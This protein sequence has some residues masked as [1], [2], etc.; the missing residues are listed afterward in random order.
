MVP[1][2]S[3]LLQIILGFTR[4]IRNCPVQTSQWPVLWLIVSWVFWHWSVMPSVCAEIFKMLYWAQMKESFL[5]NKNNMEYWK[6]LWW[7]CLF[8]HMKKGPIISLSL[9]FFSFL[10]FLFCF[11]GWG[12]CNRK[13]QT[14]N[15][16]FPAYFQFFKQMKL[17]KTSGRRSSNSLSMPNS[18]INQFAEAY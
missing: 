16:T 17:K 13:T 1:P 15:L 2:G 12:V 10:F 4:E 14:H 18:F 8:L 11:L 3:S 6:A 9:F 5:S 7:L